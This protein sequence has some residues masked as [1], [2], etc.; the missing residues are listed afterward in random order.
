MANY[1]IL[2]ETIVNIMVRFVNPDCNWKAQ[3]RDSVEVH[4]IMG[5]LLPC[6]KIPAYSHKEDAIGHIDFVTK[7]F[8]LC[9]FEA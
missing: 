7:N 9:G 5:V 8:S 6:V 1:E 4:N 2:E 3:G